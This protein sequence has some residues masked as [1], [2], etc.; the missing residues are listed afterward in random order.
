VNQ[1]SAILDIE[2]KRRLKRF[3]VRE[4]VYSQD[5][6]EFMGYAENLHTEGLM[7]AT[8]EPIQADQKIQIW[9]GAAKE[10]KVLSRI[11]VTAYRAWTSFSDTEDRYYYSGLQFI[12]VSEET[13]DKIE[14]L[15]EE[16]KH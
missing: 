8:N 15:L 14:T 4:K 10:D 16:V 6:D 13:S 11:F 1:L 9:F 2:E 12:G 3:S 7:I 5:T